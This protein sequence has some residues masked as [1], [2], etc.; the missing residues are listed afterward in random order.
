[1]VLSQLR[2]RCNFESS[3][4]FQYPGFTVHYESGIHDVPIFDAHVEVFSKS[5][6]VKVTW[7]TPF[8]KGLPVTMT[9]REDVDGSG[10]LRET[11]VRKTYEDPY[12]L[13]LRELYALA[14]EGKPVKTT[15][16][17]AAQD[18]KIAQM[19]MQAGVSQVA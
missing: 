3:V 4:I 9:I 16:A 11:V 7:D 10:A 8:I 14:T 17:D 18:L 6:Q 1:M 15:V 5:K 2:H 19:V 13:Q 12:T